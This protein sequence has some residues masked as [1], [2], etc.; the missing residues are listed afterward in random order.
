ML[1][2][3]SG[4]EGHALRGCYPFG[5]M[6]AAQRKITLSYE[7]PAANEDWV[8]SEEPAPESTPH[9]HTVELIRDLLEA[10]LRKR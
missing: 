2:C 4:N 5:R 6:S 8:L 3:A 1:R 7:V 9:D 10:E